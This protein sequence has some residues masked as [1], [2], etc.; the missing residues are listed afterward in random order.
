MTANCLLY[1]PPWGAGRNNALSPQLLHAE[2]LHCSHCT[3]KH[4]RKF[5][6]ATAPL[7]VGV[8]RLR[9]VLLRW[10]A[11]ISASYP[12]EAPQQ[13][14]IAKQEHSDWSDD[15]HIHVIIAPISQ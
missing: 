13:C 6:A 7:N 2:K 3:T 4:G 12:R 9:F 5:A 15:C 10:L 11:A 14:L 1:N 8:C